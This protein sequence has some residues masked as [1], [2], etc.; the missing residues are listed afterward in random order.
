MKP[1]IIR[2][3]DCSDTSALYLNDNGHVGLLLVPKG[4][5]EKIDEDKFHFAE[6]LLHAEL[7]GDICEG[8]YSTGLTMRYS[9]TSMEFS[10]VS[11]SEENGMVVTILEDQRGHRAK[12]YLRALPECSAFESTSEFENL[13]GHDELLECLTSFSLGHLS[14]FQ[15]DIGAADMEIHRFKSWWAAEGR[16]VKESAW[17]LGLEQAWA[18]HGRR[19]TL[20]G[21]DGSMPVRG[22]FPTAAVEDPVNGV[23]WGAQLYIPSA[24]QME[25]ACVENSLSFAGG[26]GDYNQAHWRKLIKNGERFTSP[27]AVIACA[28]GNIDSLCH[29]LTLAQRAGW[30]NAPQAEKMLPISFNEYC[31]TW[32][33]PS[34]E[35]VEKISNSI[36]H[37]GIRYLTIDCGWYRDDAHSWSLT[38]GDWEQNK[39]L[40]PNGLK[41]AGAYIRSLG[42]IP[43]LWFELETAGVYSKAFN[44]S[45]DFLTRDG[46]TITV[47]SRR[48]WDMENPRVVEY[49]TNKVIGTLKEGGFGYLKVDYNEVFGPGCDG[50]ESLG[51]G[52]RRKLLATQAFFNKIREQIPDI[53]IENC[54]SGGHRLEPSMMALVSQASFSDAH[55]SF[56]I[57]VIAANLHRLILPAQSQIWAVVR[58]TN[59]DNRLYYS[60]LSTLLG[61]MCLSG[62]IF[63]LNARQLEIIDECIRFYRAA[64]PIIENGLSKLLTPEQTHYRSLSGIQCVWRE[65]GERALIVVHRFPGQGGRVEL[66]ACG[67]VLLHAGA[68]V[69]SFEGQTLN[70]QAGGYSAD[71]YMVEI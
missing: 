20:F 4:M 42:M 31:T 62:D 8:E 59:D 11:Q 60:L 22:Y 23:L 9:Q 68:G 55:E 65:K 7:S 69:S 71:A 52:L 46:H 40:F 38:T 18:D 49:L 63:D 16:H 13:S 58:K 61:R 34:Y 12:H 64:A 70:V 32:G 41:E 3:F 53:V 10:L 28:K 27:K 1:E 67:R 24:W 57:P 6:P 50:Y 17:S 37:M 14:P 19:I 43:G 51:E 56:D 25:V 54:A 26:L 35:N 2:R 29:R 21:C 30:D 39:T 36:Q 5:E 47:G 33:N 44:I 48:F 15:G 45:H 66:P